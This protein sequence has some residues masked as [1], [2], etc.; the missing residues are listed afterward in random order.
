MHC[1]LL[2]ATVYAKEFTV[3]RLGK[4]LMALIEL[5]ILLYRALLFFCSSEKLASYYCYSDHLESSLP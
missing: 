5:D 4:S 3:N 1:K 2:D